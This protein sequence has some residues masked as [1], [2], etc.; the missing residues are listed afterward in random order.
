MT[1]ADFAFLVKAAAA[2]S[3]D[4]DKDRDEKSAV[5]MAQ[6]LDVLCASVQASMKLVK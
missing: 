2:S 3:K 6:V 5:H 4:K 1:Q